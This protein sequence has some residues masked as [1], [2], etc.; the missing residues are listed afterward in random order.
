[1]KRQ[2]KNSELGMKEKR[3]LRGTDGQL[4]WVASQTQPDTAFDACAACVSL[5]NPT[6]GDIHMANKSIRQLKAVNIALH[7]NDIGN[8]EEASILYYRDSSFRNLKG[9]NSQG[10]H[11][12]STSSS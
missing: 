3:L 8:V 4:N 1:M 7:F 12:F 9:E 10:G 11:S 2:N 5:K 6:L